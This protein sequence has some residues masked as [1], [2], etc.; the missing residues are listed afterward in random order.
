MHVIKDRLL[1][2]LDDL[3]MHSR[4][5]IGNPN[6]EMHHGGVILRVYDLTP[7]EIITIMRTSYTNIVYEQNGI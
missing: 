4:F 1:L 6:S 7:P 5:R 2:L 3:K